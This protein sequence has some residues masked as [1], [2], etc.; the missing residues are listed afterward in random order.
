MS[1]L[2]YI[3]VYVIKLYRGKIFVLDCKSG[4]VDGWSMYMYIDMKLGVG[5]D[6]LIVK[7]L[8]DDACPS[9]TLGTVDFSCL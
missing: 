9:A 1:V 6:T 2:I 3:H 7:Q 5:G 8:F 4:M